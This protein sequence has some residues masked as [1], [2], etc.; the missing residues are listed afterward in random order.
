MRE[1]LTS[2]GW[3][4]VSGAFSINNFEHTADMRGLGGWV[5]GCLRLCDGYAQRTPQ[6]CGISMIRSCR[7]ERAGKLCYGQE[8]LQKFVSSHKAPE[9]FVHDWTLRCVLLFYLK[10]ETHTIHATGYP[11]FHRTPSCRAILKYNTIPLPP[12]SPAPFSAST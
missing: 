5:A 12:P 11:P 1:R 7:G 8:D 6:M 3:E 2:G 4:S 10:E 9:D